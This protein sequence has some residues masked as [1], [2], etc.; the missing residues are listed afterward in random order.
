MEKKTIGISFSLKF[1][2]IKDL[3]P[4]FAAARVAIAYA[5]RNRN[6]SSISKEVFEAALPSLMN[7]PLV[8]RYDAENNDFGSHDIRVVKNNDG[9]YEVVAAT[10]P[11]GVVPESSRFEWKTVT[12]KDGTEN[13]YLFCDVILW[14]RQ[15]GYECLASQDQWSQSMEIGVNSY[16]IDGD[17]YCVIESMDF[18]ALCILGSSVTPCF[19]SASVQM[20]SDIAVSDYRQQFTLMLKELK[21]FA[22]QEPAVFCFKG[23]KET[24]TAE[25]RE[26]ILGEYNLKT[27]DV[28]F[29]L[30]EDMTEEQFRSAIEDMIKTPSVPE[31]FSASYR[32]KRDALCN[33]LTSE[34]VKDAMGK[35]VSETYYWVDDFDDEFV[36]VERSTWTADN[37][38]SKTGRFAY[39]FETDEAGVLTANITGEFEEM[40]KRW[41][42]LE[43]SAKLDQSRD[44]FE[45]LEKE[46]ADYKKDYSTPESEVEELRTFKNEVVKANHEAEADEVLAEFEDL[47]GNEEFAA[48]KESAYGFEKIEDLRK[49]CYAIRGKV[50]SVG[51]QFSYTPKKTS[52]KIPLKDEP[53]VADK[54]GYGELFSKY[55]RK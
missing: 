2:E 9:G 32:K 7:C 13:E 21:E 1:E 46:F 35:V 23:G 54:T 29:E 4:S 31:S 10:V 27:E 37:Y 42:T 22:A 40:V 14:K 52:V 48:L 28:K 30:T 26:K 18:E 36:Y 45:A 5:G 51:K 19:E 16:I 3:N 43:E 49:E 24:L 8:G 15:Y 12:E 20:K 47:N 55:G 39:V 11:Y 25:Q 50:A 33:A 17:G 53:E 38:E 34:V 41:L 44:T 6:M